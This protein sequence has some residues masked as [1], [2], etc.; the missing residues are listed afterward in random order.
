MG[1]C[2]AKVALK[3][4]GTGEKCPDVRAPSHFPVLGF[5]VPFAKA[6]ASV[7]S[8]ALSAWVGSAQS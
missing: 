6:L 2:M 1:F 4:R 7:F 5:V 8:V 3:K